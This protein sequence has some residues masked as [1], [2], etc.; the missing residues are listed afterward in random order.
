MFATVLLIPTAKYPFTC[1][2]SLPLAALELQNSEV[3]G[4]PG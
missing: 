1:P 2:S 3:V 4:K